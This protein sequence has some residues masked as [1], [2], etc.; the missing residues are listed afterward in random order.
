[1]SRGYRSSKRKIRKAFPGT[2]IAKSK[3]KSKNKLHNTKLIDKS[4]FQSEYNKLESLT[5]TSDSVSIRI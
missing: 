1:M 3:S 4:I 2:N 5:T